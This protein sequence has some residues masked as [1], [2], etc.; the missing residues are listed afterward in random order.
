M[1]RIAICDDEASVRDTLRR[2]FDQLEQAPAMNVRLFSSA[3]ALLQTPD[4]FDILLI[5]VQMDGMD[6]ISA[7]R[8][9]RKRGCQTLILFIT[10]YI[11]YAIDGYEVQAYH[12]LK[13]PVSFDRFSV[14]MRGA[15][16]LAQRRTQTSITLSGY[17]QHI[18]L[19]LSRILYCETNRGHIIVHTVNDII[20]STQSMTQ[21]EALV[22]GQ[23]FFRIHTAYLINLSAV[24]KLL[25]AQVQLTDGTLLPVSKHRKREFREILAFYWGGNF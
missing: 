15:L 16:A 9:L 3:E 12:F 10:N 25:P 22:H 19:P 18:T 7:A 11:Q 1:I 17:D 5:D 21:I 14:V 13:K 2:Y 6:G 20:H 8:Q 24:E 4:D 23:N